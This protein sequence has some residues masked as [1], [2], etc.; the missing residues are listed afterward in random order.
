MQARYSRY[1]VYGKAGNPASQVDICL[2][3]KQQDRKVL[4]LFSHTADILVVT[5]VSQKDT[6]SKISQQ[7]PSDTGLGVEQSR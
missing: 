4:Y 2:A 3:P 7:G 6:K 1:L 5:S